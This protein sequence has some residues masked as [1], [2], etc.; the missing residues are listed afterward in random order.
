M[1][2]VRSCPAAV[3]WHSEEEDEHETEELELCA[4]LIALQ[5]E[6][7]RVDRTVIRT[8][9]GRDLCIA[10]ISEDRAWCDYRFNFQM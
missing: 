6:T 10:D 4:A 8:V 7:V 2:L 9:R 5:V 3:G 1:P